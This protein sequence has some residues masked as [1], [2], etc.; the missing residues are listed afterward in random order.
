MKACEVNNENNR[1]KPKLSQEAMLD[2]VI[3]LNKTS[4][5][6]EMKANEMTEDNYHEEMTDMNHSEE[7]GGVYENNIYDFECDEHT[8]NK[9]GN[10]LGLYNHSINGR[11]GGK[12]YST[13]QM[14]LLQ[15]ENE[16]QKRMKNAHQLWSIDDIGKLELL[17]ILSKHNCTNGVYKDIMGWARFYNTQRSSNLFKRRKVES[18]GVVLKEIQKRRNME[19]MK[20]ILKKVVLGIDSESPASDVFES[21]N[22]TDVST[23]CR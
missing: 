9:N 2:Y 14:S 15:Q 11:V 5:G 21:R 16:F 4:S 8:R 19:L 18:R 13:K 23:I 3:G 20:P 17:N 12:D 1:K 22:L 7:I 6:K 10:Y